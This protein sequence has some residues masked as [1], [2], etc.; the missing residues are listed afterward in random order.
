MNAVDLQAMSDP[1]DAT[2][3][4]DSVS[5]DATSALGY[6]IA[7]FSQAGDV[8]ALIG[9]LG[10]GKT[11]LVRGLTM[12]LGIDPVVVSSPTYVLVQQYDCPRGQSTLLHVDAY[13][14]DDPDSIG[15]GSDLFEQAVVAVEWADRL[16]D[17]LP[18]DRLE[19]LMAHEP[20]HHRRLCVTGH[21]SWRPRAGP[22]FNAL[23]EVVV[24]GHRAESDPRSA[25]D[26]LKTD[27][28]AP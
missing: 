7:R 24:G 23:E 20:D 10:T 17:Q 2:W 6:A 26:A 8:V 22:L 4:G 16:A 19:V 3:T 25:P 21:G 28:G 12:G 1:S 5:P 9:E 14:L 27:D 15:W 18:V 11:Q 13:R